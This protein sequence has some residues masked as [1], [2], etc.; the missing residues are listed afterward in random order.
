MGLE[1]GLGIA[2]ST[3]PCVLRPFPEF[4]WY[5]SGLVLLGERLT[6]M[7]WL[8]IGA[9]IAASVGTMAS[10]VQSADAAP[11]ADPPVIGPRDAGLVENAA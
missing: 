10:A 7:Q 3:V 8:A 4:V 9:I 2:R 6:P 1:K 11:L 5:I